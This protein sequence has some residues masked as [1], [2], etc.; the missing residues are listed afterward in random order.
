MSPQHSTARFFASSSALFG[1]AANALGTTE[2]SYEIAGRSVLLRC[3]GTELVGR[4]DPALSALRHPKS[5]NQPDLTVDL[6]DSATS[7]IAMPPPPWPAHEIAPLGLVR[8]YCDDRFRTAVDVHTA[9]LLTFDAATSRG[10]FW[11]HDARR[12]AYWQSASPLRL[13]LSWWGSARAMQL[14]H[15]GAVGHGGR[16]AL[17]VGGA[18]AGKSTISLACLGAGLDY[19]GDDYCLVAVEPVPRVHGVYATAKLRPDA[20]A[21]LPALAGHVRNP[22]RLD[23]EKAILD[24]PRSDLGGLPA[25]AEIRAIIAPRVTGRVVLRPMTAGAALRAMAPSTIFGLF[26]A[27]PGSLATLAGLAARVPGYELEVNDDVDRVADTV[28]S[29]LESS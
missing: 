23:R 22:S 9:S 25:G 10:G 4:T 11:L 21:L 19:F 14:T 6:W 1:A 29:L 20:L 24:L 27:T 26:G 13:I 15:A 12:M 5:A 2:L 7:G 16:A 28:I 17:L 8:S 18:G 3:V